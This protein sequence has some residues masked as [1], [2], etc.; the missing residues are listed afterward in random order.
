M[1]PMPSPADQ[2]QGS[3]RVILVDDD[4][5]AR[6]SLRRLLADDGEVSI[7]GEFANAHQALEGVA[8]LAP[9]AILVDVE[10]PGQDGF[11]LV[12]AMPREDRPYVVF[13]TAHDRYALDAFAS[14]AVDYVLKPVSRDRLREAIRRARAQRDDE[15]LASWARRWHPQDGA[16]P[17]LAPYLAELLVRIGSRAI[18]IPVPELEWIEA[19]SYYARLHTGGRSYL[20]REPLQRLEQR[21]NPADFLRVHR[22]AI[23]NLNRVREIRYEAPG[24]R[25][26]I[27]ASGGHVRVSRT[28]W[29]WFATQLRQ[30]TSVTPSDGTGSPPGART[31]S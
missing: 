28:R 13:V 16:A 12:K 31:A 8:R 26:L 19:D 10:M 11:E 21:L 25:V 6:R 15:R 17:P 18:V 5:L 4:P 23:V 2:T 1:F 30:R 14:H 20:L 27:M 7:V 29:R 24:E 3:M 22:S 9:D